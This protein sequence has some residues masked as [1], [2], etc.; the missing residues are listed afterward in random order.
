MHGLLQVQREERTCM[1]VR[2]CHHACS[3]VTHSGMMSVARVNRLCPDSSPPTT[4][5]T[6]SKKCTLTGFLKS[7]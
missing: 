4:R 2:A 3:V 5:M 6:T 1:H 7:T